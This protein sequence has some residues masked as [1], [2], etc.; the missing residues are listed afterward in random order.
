VTSPRAG[1]NQ[2]GFLKKAKQVFGRDA[3]SSALNHANDEI[4]EAVTNFNVSIKD[5]RHCYA[6]RIV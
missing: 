6:K 5:S 4:V 3:I 2:K 1:D